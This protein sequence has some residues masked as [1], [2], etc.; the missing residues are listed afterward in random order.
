MD[1]HREPRRRGPAPV[2][3]IVS[4]LLLVVVTGAV[5]YLYRGG[6]KGSG[7][8]PQPL[9]AP[10]GDVRIAAPP[11]PAAQDA[12]AGLSIAK[13]DPT[14]A[15][16]GAPNF[17]P[18]PEQPLPP[19][20]A[21]QTNPS[22]SASM[23][24][25]PPTPEPVKAAVSSATP[26]V[27]AG[28]SATKAITPVVPKSV[29]PAAAKSALVQAAAPATSDAAKGAAIV[30][31]GAFSSRALADKGW[32]AAAAAAPGAMAGKGEQV[33]EVAKDGKTLY[34]TSITGFAS[35]DQAQALCDRLKSA[36]GTCIVH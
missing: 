27:G 21:A 7:D 8:G 9:G 15:S 18:P 32:S 11:Q 22:T 17:A 20:N 1:D 30:Q 6:P 33:V 25:P 34:R 3:L 5:A 16:A 10:L 26:P 35:H 24:P 28:P 36:G 2:T 13:D 19:A 31:I 29:A 23:P 12:T 14:A 4:V